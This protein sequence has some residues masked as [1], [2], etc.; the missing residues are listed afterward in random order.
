MTI[1]ARFDET[2][3]K[4]NV[5]TRPA[6]KISEYFAHHPTVFK[7]ALVCNHFFRAAAMAGFMTVL[8]FSFPVNVGICAASSLFYRLTVEPKCAF[9]FALPAFAGATAAFIANPALS[10]AAFA[11]M[12]AFTAACGNLIPLSLYAAYVILTVDH[13]VNRRH[14]FFH[15]QSLH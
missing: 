2:I 3:S 9:K 13:D 12:Q 11:S 4:Y 15:R 1:S 8:P 7:A 5:L 6:Q 14:C 10:R